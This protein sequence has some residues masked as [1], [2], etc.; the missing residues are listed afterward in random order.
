MLI[1]LAAV[2]AVVWVLWRTAV[3]A[4]LEMQLVAALQAQGIEVE[5]LEVTA[6][7]TTRARIERVELSGP[8]APRVG[9]IVA[10]YDIG[11][12]LTRR[13]VE[14][15]EVSDASLTIAVGADGRA[16]VVGLPATVDSRIPGPPTLPFGR[17][18]VRD[19]RVRI[20]GPRLEIEVPVTAVV[21]VLPD[22]SLMVEGDAAPTTAIGEASLRIDAAMDR[23]GRIV[24][25][26]V[27]LDADVTHGALRAGNI[28]GWLALERASNGAVGMTAQLTAEAVET[29]VAVLTGA[30][31]QFGMEERSAWALVRADQADSDGAVRIDAAIDGEE[32]RLDASIETTDLEALAAPVIRPG[33]V[34]GH[35]K[36]MLSAR[37]DV[38]PL[39]SGWKGAFPPVAGSSTIEFDVD[40]LGGYLRE[41][42]GVLGGNVTFDGSRFV[43]SGTVPWQ[44]SGTLP[45]LAPAMLR[46]FGSDRK[47]VVDL[48]GSPTAS[49]AANY[50]VEASA[51]GRGRV[52]ARIS[53]AK[54]GR[55][56]FAINRL[57][58]SS[59]PVRLGGT[60]LT[61]E[62]L[63]LS[64]RG[65]AESFE[66]R[67][68]ATATADGRL[69]GGTRIE[70][71]VV[72]VAGDVSFAGRVFRFEPDGCT[73]LA[74]GGIAVAEA[75]AVPGGIG[76][77]ATPR[78]ENEFL[79]MRLGDGFEAAVSFTTGAAAFALD[80]LGDGMPTVTEALLPALAV[81]AA[82]SPEAGLVLHAQA[83]GGRLALADPGMV[84]SGIG[85][86]FT[87]GAGADPVGEVDWQIE[88][89]RIL[90]DPAPLVPL[91]ISGNARIKADEV[92]FAGKGVGARGGIM[93]GFDG[94][95]RWGLGGHA[96]FLLEP[97]SLA[98]GVRR[99]ADV[100]PALAP[101]QLASVTGI[102]EGSGRYGW[103]DAAGS[104]A[105]VALRDLSFATPYMSVGGL[106]ADL[107]A[108]SLLPLMLP[109]G[110]RA[111][112]RVLDIG[113]PLE[114]GEVTFSVSG[115]GLLSVTGTTFDWAG[116]R[117]GAE[118]FASSW[119]DP[120]R[121]IVLS[122]EGID[123]AE[124][125][126]EMAIDGLEV[127]GRLDGR[128]PIRLGNDM[129]VIDH[130]VLNTTGPGII[131]YAPVAPPDLGQGEDGSLNL[132]LEALRNFH[133]ESV[134]VTLDGRT[135]RDMEARLEIRGANPDLYDG[136]PI[137]LNVDVSGALDRILR[138]G[139]AAARYADQV[140][141]FYRERLRDSV[142]D[143]FLDDI[144]GI[145]Q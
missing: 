72:S 117:V 104:S 69:P 38:D 62:A 128:I 70:E 130:A 73:E 87:F 88:D 84:A 7:T 20:S 36:L 113:I 2:I 76:L 102:V 57:D 13:R 139:L 120:D 89:L 58:F 47:L 79:A 81:D 75:A 118:P 30:V 86:S 93:V 32:V 55:V 34:S 68:E 95:H 51:A 40:A 103:G 59:A 6:L 53:M 82:F 135:G 145:Q 112:I 98:P 43:L 24:A 25:D 71:G 91:Q 45:G 18:S 122:A 42:A 121:E 119:D 26:I 144:E 4:F 9:T 21:D 63:T 109:P 141:E 142:T 60:R 123:L 19:S 52:D 136:Y 15:V 94:R 137:S 108:D 29:P 77:C 12:L 143:D 49:L 11:T 48:A 64:G 65:S 56:G 129:I 22:G 115:D 92:A 1:G 28:K 54:D 110:Q 67:I 3:P 114:N 140:E 124:L 46:M 66:G 41:V 80:L 31:F 35:G 125:L 134:T 5:H 33:P 10:V 96:S 100:F 78:P 131:R 116:G 111:T 138:Q 107:H 85:G 44:L 74:A 23:N 50:E 17:I 105:D 106:S 39:L 61:V 97:V 133:Y 16:G 14:R 99:P 127:T 83:Q 8:D 126:A 27:M 132:L 90:G 101:L 37:L